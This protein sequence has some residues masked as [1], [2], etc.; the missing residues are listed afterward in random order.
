MI[1]T[2]DAVLVADRQDS[3][4]VRQVVDVLA[5]RGRPEATTHAGEVRPWGQFTVLHEGAGFKVKEVLVDPGRAL[6]LQ[7]HPGR[8]ETWVVVEGAA[9]VEL[10]G[11]TLTLEAGRSLRV[12]RGARHRLANPGPARLRLIEVGWGEALGD[13]ATVRLEP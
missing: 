3:D 9:R 4:A 11:G 2:A 1:E 7:F 6:T 10:D 5:R 12:P 8:D 13:E